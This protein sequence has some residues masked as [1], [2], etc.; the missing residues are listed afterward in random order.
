MFVLTKL[1]FCG[2]FIAV[3][4]SSSTFCEVT[5]QPVNNWVTYKEQDFYIISKSCFSYMSSY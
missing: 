3:R 4:G 1:R 5:H 2:I